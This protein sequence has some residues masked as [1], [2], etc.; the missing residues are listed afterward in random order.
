MN[1]R[2][3]NSYTAERFSCL[4]GQFTISAGKVTRCSLPLKSP[5]IL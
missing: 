5:C 4:S 3:T 1:T 2:I